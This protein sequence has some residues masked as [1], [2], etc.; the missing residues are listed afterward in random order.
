MESAHILAITF[1]VLLV[2]LV[3]YIVASP[4]Q[5][6]QVQPIHRYYIENEPDWRSR[7]GWGN[8]WRRWG[9]G[10]NWRDRWN[11]GMGGMLTVNH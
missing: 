3:L 4:A 10:W 1:G 7:W 5:N 8:G 2:I 9:N 6:Q 11:H